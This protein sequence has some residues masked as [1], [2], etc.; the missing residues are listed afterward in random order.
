MPQ[1]LRRLSPDV[2]QDPGRVL[3]KATVN[4]ARELG[5]TQRDMAQA[6]GVSEATASRMQGGAYA[7]SGKPFELA[8][9]LVRI[10]RSLDAIAGSDPATMQGWMRHANADLGQAPKEMIADVAG[11]IDV[12]NY[13]D[14][15]RAVT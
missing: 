11:L 9:C 14:A 15:A 5:L 3:A 13:L 4:A 12:M 10:Y 1:T 7:L 6:I 8:A 2:S